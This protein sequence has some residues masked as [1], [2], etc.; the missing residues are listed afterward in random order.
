MAKKVAKPARNSVKKWL[1]FRSLACKHRKLAIALSS[2]IDTYVTG[3]FKAE[4]LAHGGAGDRPVGVLNPDR[5]LRANLEVGRGSS[6][7]LRS[8]RREGRRQMTGAGGGSCRMSI[9]RMK[10]SRSFKLS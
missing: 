9:P 5:H 3:T 7:E 1:P 8:D 4:V 6:V 2:F 10:A